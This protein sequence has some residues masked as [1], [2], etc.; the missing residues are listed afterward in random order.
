MRVICLF[1]AIA[2]MLPFSSCKGQTSKQTSKTGTSEKVEA[3]YFHFN[4]RCVTCKTVEAEAKADIEL[5][6]PY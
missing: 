1:I 2:L 3:Y 4:A 5:L 6:Y